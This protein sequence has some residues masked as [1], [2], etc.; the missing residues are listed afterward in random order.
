MHRA[1]SELFARSALAEEERVSVGLGREGELLA[2]SPH[3]RGLTD[4]AIGVGL[5][6]LAERSVGKKTKR[7]N[8]FRTAR[9]IEDELATQVHHVTHADLCGVGRDAV[10][11]E[12]ALSQALDVRPV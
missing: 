11:L 4:H 3:A 7:R 12:R 8:F 5:A 1:R 6:E 2:K 10:D 9:A